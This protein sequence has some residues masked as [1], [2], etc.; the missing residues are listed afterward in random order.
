MLAVVVSGGVKHRV[1]L[2]RSHV[3]Q[4][5][6]CQFWTDALSCATG[7]STWVFYFILDRGSLVL[8]CAI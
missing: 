2:N 8:D 7:I 3:M 4:S 6:S 5:I 1:M